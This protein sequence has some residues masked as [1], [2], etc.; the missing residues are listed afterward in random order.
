MIVRPKSIAMKILMK[1]LSVV[2]GLTLLAGATAAQAQDKADCLAIIV[3]PG[4]TL[5]DVSTADL[6]RYFRAD[7]TKAPD[8]SKLS[9]VMLDAGRPERDA[10]LKGIYKMSE[11]EYNDFSLSAPLLPAHGCRGTQVHSPRPQS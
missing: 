5:T 2:L 9:I 11:A 6:G 8:G 10:A 1:K 4:S 3:G 7:K